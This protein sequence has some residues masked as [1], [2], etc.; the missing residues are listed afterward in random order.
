MSHR[1]VQPFLTDDDL[2]L[3][4]EGRHYRAYDKL[5]AHPGQVD[6]IDGV[7]FTVVAPNAS[8]VSRS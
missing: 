2:Q 8:A 3:L 5:G 1:L 6:G 7:H 4:G